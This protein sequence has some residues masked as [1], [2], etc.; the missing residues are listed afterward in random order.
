[1]RRRVAGLVLVLWMFGGGR[2]AVRC[3]GPAWAEEARALQLG[4]YIDL[5][6]RHN[7]AYAAQGYDPRIATAQIDIARIFPD[8]QLSGGAAAL[9]ITRSGYNPTT[10]LQLEW[11]I[12]LGGKRGH[13]I[14]VAISQREVVR[15]GLADALRLLRRDAALDFIEALRVRLVL[16]RKRQTLEG[17][18]KLVHFNE[19]SFRAGQVGEIVVVQARVEARRFA[20]EVTRAE[21]DVRAA[22]LQLALRMGLGADAALPGEPAADL[23]VA[24][25]HFELAALLA[26]AEE[27][28]PDVLAARRSQET[29]ERQVGLARANRWIDVSLTAGWQHG[30]AGVLPN[31][32]NVP[33]DILF[34]TLGV[35]LPLSRAYYGE[36]N[37]ARFGAAQADVR[38]KAAEQQVAIEVRTALARYEGAAAALGE[39]S[40]GLL[41]DAEKVLAAKL[42]DYER[43]GAT[44]LEVITAQR[45]VNDVYLAYFDALAEHARALVT[46]QAAAG[47]W[48]APF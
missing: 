24:P 46:V 10:T 38:R 25:R 16:E 30:F 3:G 17:F 8:P 19:E 43:G 35:P 41:A 29:S 18:R 32:P 11:P 42:Y 39:Y 31:Y 23:R 45:A 2:A 22:D 27:M 13:R 20:V 26:T 34:F 1:M 48:D 14:D 47:L 5:V 4:E 36:L 7:L 9:E 28:R 15:A 33:F 44:Q 21:A 37:A 12:E 6:E 40:A